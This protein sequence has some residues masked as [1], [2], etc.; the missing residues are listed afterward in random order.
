[1]PRVTTEGRI[2]IPKRIRDALGLHAGAELEIRRE[3][4]TVLLRKL[5]DRKVIDGWRG[6][7][8]VGESV[9]DF[10]NRLRGAR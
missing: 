5:E 2:T 7:L 6:A 1:M 4:A 9:D 10:V 8:D 3:G